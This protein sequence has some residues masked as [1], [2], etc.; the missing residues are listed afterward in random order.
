MKEFKV[1]SLRFKV[2]LADIVCFGHML[3]GVLRV[4]NA[5]KCRGEQSNVQNS[6]SIMLQVE[7]RE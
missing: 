2:V 4:Q 3:S 6:C 1:E 7:A 5:V